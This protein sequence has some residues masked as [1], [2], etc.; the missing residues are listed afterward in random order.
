MNMDVSPAHLKRW[1]GRRADC[2]NSKGG[3]VLY[4]ALNHAKARALPEGKHSDGQGLWLVKRNKQLGKW[5]L[6]LTIHGKRREM[7]LGPWPDV[8]IAEARERA[9]GARKTV[10]DG[11][12][13]IV[14]RVRQRAASRTLSVKEA[15]DGCF[16]ARQAELKRDGEAGRWMSP[17]KVHVVPRLGQSQ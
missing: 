8:S 16:K 11:L 6:R 4:N 2:S 9:A 14:E 17:L 13:P 10:R 5:I 1:A 12:D 15:I 7:G 3:P